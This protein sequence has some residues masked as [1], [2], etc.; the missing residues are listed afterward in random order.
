MPVKILL[1]QA[2]T[3]DDPARH[4]E[5]RSF[6]L[7]AGLPEDRFVPQDLLGG[8]PSLRMVRR[9]DALMVGGSGDFYVT[10]GDLPEFA[11]LLD[12]LADV[13][14]TGHPTFASCFGFHLLVRALGGELA[15][16]P[17][18]TEVG[19]FQVSLTD[20]GRHDELFGSLSERFYAQVGRKD[21]AT[22][23][24][25]SVLHLASSE[26]CPYHALRA[27]KRPIWATQFH[28]ELDVHENRQRFLRY[29]KGYAPHLDGA[30]TEVL[31]G[32]FRAS[33]ETEHLIPRFLRLVFG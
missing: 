12:V 3:P 2:R 27:P 29:L 4:D 24:P 30:P 13:V 21:R 22:M 1:L 20:A 8:P 10:K 33:P 23:L 31:N 17:D 32:R 14:D 6:A 9:F 7:K 28:P 5:V 18:A 15:H 11:K 26:R 16:D 19:T 25:P